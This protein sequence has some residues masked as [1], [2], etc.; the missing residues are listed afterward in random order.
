MQSLLK[1][2]HTEEKLLIDPDNKNKY[3]MEMGAVP[4]K[5]DNF[6]SLCNCSEF[7]WL[8]DCSERQRASNLLCCLILCCPH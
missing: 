7:S 6:D 2:M 3:T 8:C 1:G 4:A 5:K